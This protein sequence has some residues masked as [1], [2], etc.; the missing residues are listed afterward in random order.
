MTSLVPA[1]DLVEQRLEQ[2][3]LIGDGVLANVNAGLLQRLLDDGGNLLTVRLAVFQELDTLLYHSVP[4][5]DHVFGHVLQQ[6]EETAFGVEPCVRPQLFIVRLQALDDTRDA[7]VVVPLGTVQCPD[8]QVDNA[9]V[10]D[11]LFGVVVGDLLLLFLNL[12]H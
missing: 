9:E 7:K 4:Q 5:H 10:E 2:S 12:S 1:N 6:R 8:H 3:S 11:L